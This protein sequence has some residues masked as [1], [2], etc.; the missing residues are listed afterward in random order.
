MSEAARRESNPSG[1]WSSSADQSSTSPRAGR[2]EPQLCT[3]APHMQSNSLATWGSFSLTAWR[4]SAR[5]KTESAGS[6]WL[7]VVDRGAVCRRW[8]PSVGR[9]QVACQ[10]SSWL[11]SIDNVLGG[12]QIRGLGR[13][14]AEQGV[15]PPTPRGPL[16]RLRLSEQCVAGSLSASAQAA[17]TRPSVVGSAR[18]GN[19][20]R[21]LQS[22]HYMR[23]HVHSRDLRFGSVF[24][25]EGRG[26]DG[27]LRA[28]FVASASHDGLACVRASGPARPSASW[29]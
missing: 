17:A 5:S 24:V 10:A 1:L 7:S 28:Q 20:A 23:A 2:S 18:G 25:R 6:A 3:S 29:S 22:V 26:V 12:A 21:A 11:R 8:P 19:A 4:P 15:Q 14:R 9:C 13:R 16:E 27:A